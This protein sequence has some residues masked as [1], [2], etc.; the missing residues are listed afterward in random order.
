M[1]T[2]IYF[3]L[4]CLISFIYLNAQ[5][6]L[7]QNGNFSNGNTGWTTSGNW[8]ISSSFSCY[9][10]ASAYA[11]A[12]NASG[13][14]IIN[15][16]GNL[17][18]TITIPSNSTSATLSFYISQNTQET[19]AS[20]ADYLEIYF[21]NSTGSTW[22]KTFVHISS[23]SAGSYP[24]CQTYKK[25]T[26]DVLAFKGQTI[27]LWFHVF[28]DGGPNNTMFRVD[29]V[30]LIYIEP[31]GTVPGEAT[32]TGDSEGCAGTQM[33]FSATAKDATD[34]IWSAP[35]CTPSSGTG[36]SFT[37]S[38]N[39]SGNISIT[40][41]PSNSYGDGT[42]GT[43]TVIVKSSPSTPVIKAQGDITSF[44]QG[45]GSVTLLVDNSENGNTYSWHPSGIGVSINVTN[46]GTYYCTSSNTCGGSSPA[47]NSI[48][49][50]VNTVP[51]VSFTQSGSN[52]T[53]NFSDNTTGNPISWNWNFGDATS[54]DNTSILQNPIHSFSNN[55]IYNVSLQATNTCGSNSSSHN[56]TIGNCTNGIEEIYLVYIKDIL[57]FPNPVNKIIQINFSLLK[58]EKLSI[59][60][61][62]I[63]GKKI[64]TISESVF[65][66]GN[67][68]I[69]FLRPEKLASGAYFIKFD[70]NEFSVS[71]KIYFK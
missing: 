70:S 40:A 65:D 24:G 50:N 19:S 10:S 45:A 25:Y 43:K 46:A 2:K 49:I 55:G 58:N 23:S 29:D 16:Y 44:C 12:G 62:D 22:I 64:E 32:V 35:D 66:S 30:S 11:Y 42:A 4:I 8:L 3:I 54:Q 20:F 21:Y 33:T 26:Y 38:P 68:S 31:T 47:S 6:E 34:Y 51:S 52:C 37:T 15:E 27:Q 39:N 41:T 9:N 5:T 60:L 67:N 1:K 36:S 69:K 59:Y 56:I 7:I 61:L 48:N 71:K 13:S 14:P 28:S 18:Q 53:F 57:I 63:L 17:K